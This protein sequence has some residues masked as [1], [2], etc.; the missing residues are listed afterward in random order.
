MT[1][2]AK[3]KDIDWVLFICVI[4]LATVGFVMQFSVAG[5]SFTP[6]A[7]KHGI[8]FLLAIL[9]MFTIAIIDIRFWYKWA[10]IFFAFSILLLIY[11]EFFGHIGMGAK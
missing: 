9:L 1:N 6:W 8:R 10:W 3:I 11:V 2:I 4:L 5:G 7:I